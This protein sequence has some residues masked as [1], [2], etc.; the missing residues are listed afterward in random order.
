[1]NR[2]SVCRHCQDPVFHFPGATFDIVGHAFQK[3][4]SS[5]LSPSRHLSSAYARWLL[6]R[7]KSNWRSE[8]NWG[9]EENMNVSLASTGYRLNRNWRVQLRTHAWIHGAIRHL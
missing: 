3:R 9:S 4:A 7:I 2:R 6:N 1:R 5:P 8:E